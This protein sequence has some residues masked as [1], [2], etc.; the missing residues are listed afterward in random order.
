MVKLS[1][2]KKINKTI[3]EF[4][5]NEGDLVLVERAG[6]GKLLLG[7][8]EE[9]ETN[10]KE[11]GYKVDWRICFEWS[12]GLLPLLEIGECVIPMF[13]IDKNLAPSYVSNNYIKNIYVG[14][15][16]ITKRLKELGNGNEIYANFVEKM[17]TP[18]KIKD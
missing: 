2:E 8:I 5:L 18:Y 3:K 13:A 14:K 1:L 10:L 4:E 17:Q 9:V 7:L 11:E 16:E 6:T 12:L 15:E